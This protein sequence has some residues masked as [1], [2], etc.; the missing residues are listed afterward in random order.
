M[1]PCL[2]CERNTVISKMR[3][4]YLSCRNAFVQR[5]GCGK[6]DGRNDRTGKT[7][8]CILVHFCTTG[9]RTTGSTAYCM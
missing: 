3:S 1:L 7:R 9:G 2:A 4:V 6:D 5:F 8:V